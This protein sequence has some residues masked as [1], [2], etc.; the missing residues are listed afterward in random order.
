MWVVATTAAAGA[1]LAVVGIWHLPARMYP[2][3]GD[4]DAR[5]VLQSGLL[6]VA[7]ALV[8]VT[9]GLV[10]LDETRQANAE[11]R[12]ANE[13][14]HVREL[15]TNAIE[16]LGSG[17]VTIRLGG[18]YA[19]ERI[20]HDSPADQRAVV[21]VL[22]AFVRTAGADRGTGAAATRTAVPAAAQAPPTLAAPDG[23]AVPPTA[24]VRA[25]VQ[26]LARLARPADLTGAALA[27]LAGLA[28]P[29]RLTHLVL[30]EAD[31]N[32]AR[33]AGADLSGTQLDDAN[34]AG[35]DLRRANLTDTIL[36]D[37]NLAGALLADAIL[38]RALLFGARLTGARLNGAD[39]TGAQLGRADLTRV[40]L[41]G[42]TLTG[43]QGLTQSQVNAAL[44][45]ERT[46]LPAGLLRPASWG[47]EDRQPA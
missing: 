24:D 39:L 2:D 35:A 20:V 46:R 4:T 12:R 16:Q 42:A 17:N 19:L 10:A 13:N 18:I 41:A 33:L 8:A 28:E 38:T 11:I 21:E 26:I 31:L 45:D 23:P 29:V 30:T 37:A 3:A 44:G 40:E 1:V 36:I 34:L 5:A 14:T 43:A 7:A 9:G 6:T 25:A 27:R 47:P 15:Y 22:S 32:R